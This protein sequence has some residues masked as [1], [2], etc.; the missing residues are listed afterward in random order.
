M[1]KIEITLNI[2][3]KPHELMIYPNETLL[4]VLR[5]R[6]DLTG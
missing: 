2:N 5:E 3:G 1:E 4:D 6:L